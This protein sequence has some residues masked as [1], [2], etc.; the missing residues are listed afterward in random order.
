MKKNNICLVLLTQILIA[1]IGI[2]ALILICGGNISLASM[3][4]DIPTLA[5]IFIFTLPSLAVSGNTQNFARAFTCAK[6]DYTVA[7]LKKADKAVSMVQK[8]VLAGGII[9]MAAATVCML[10]NLTDTAF[11][12]RNAA[13][14]CVSAVQTAVIEFLLLPVRSNVQNSLID[15]INIED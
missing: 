1:A 10:S 3:F 4:I 5:M 15:A 2:C 8:L 13:V 11:I 9:S 7:Q 14:I 6:K 12:G